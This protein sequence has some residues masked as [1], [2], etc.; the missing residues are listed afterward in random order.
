MTGIDGAGLN[1]D[2][3]FEDDLEDEDEDDLEDDLDLDDDDDFEDD[4]DDDED[5]DE[6]DE[7]DDDV[8][9]VDDEADE[10]FEDEG[11]DDAETGNGVDVDDQYEPG[12]VNSL[13]R[14]QY[15]AGDVNTISAVQE[16]ASRAPGGSRGEMSIAVL[17]YVARAMADDPDSVVIRKEERRG[18]TILRLHVAPGDMGRVIGRRGRTAQ[19]IRTLVGVAGARDGVQTVVD[20]ADD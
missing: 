1:G 15:E 5:D 9:D 20:I 7:D 14:A 11:D 12:D 13:E 8:D 16:S 4:E 2:Q 18:S 3:N 19:A 6:F 10:D 17:D